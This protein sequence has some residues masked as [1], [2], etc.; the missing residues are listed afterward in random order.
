MRNVIHTSERKDFKGCRQQWDFRSPNRMALE[1]NNQ[2]RALLFG[3]AVHKGLEVY[4]D[5]DTWTADRTAVEAMA[6]LAFKNELPNTEFLT[7]DEYA[8]E[9]K[10]GAG[11]LRSY[12]EFAKVNDKFTPKFVE[13]KFEVEIP[14]QDN[15][16]AGRIDMI[17]EDE[18]G[19]LWIV[20][21]K[22]AARFDP[23][24]FLVMDEQV[25]SYCWAIQHK[26]GIKIEGFIYNE[27][28]KD[29]AHK[30]DVLKNGTLSKNKQ[31]N[32]TYELYLTAVQEAG[33]P[34]NLYSDILEFLQNQ[35]NK[36]FRRTN[37]RRSSRELEL[38]GERISLEA[39]DMLSDPAIYPNPDRHCTYCAFRAPCLARMEGSDYEWILEGNY[40]QK[41]K[42]E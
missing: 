32:T 33:Y 28:R 8:D 9:L 7:D 30:P 20:D 18:F 40:T 21:H 41:E 36:F 4:Y 6:L 3:T 2:A 24:E 17:V 39:T 26:L 35:G 38:A 10:L 23:E 42:D 13:V 22:T 37:V 16:Y 31:Q 14:G 12:F 29:V 11:M 25:T 27:L 19:G 34:I 15:F 1:P 5:P